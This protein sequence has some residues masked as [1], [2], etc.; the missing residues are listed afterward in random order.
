[1][2]VAAPPAPA[3][4]G[5]PAAPRLLRA[6]PGRVRV[7][8]TGWDGDAADRVAG[9][10]RRIAGV[11]G[12]TVNAVTC[13]AL[14]RY[15]PDATNVER[16]VAAIGALDLGDGPARPSAPSA[17][18]AV[19]EPAPGRARARRARADGAASHP[20][21]KRRVRVAVR[22]LDRDPRVARRAVAALRGRAGVHRVEASATTGR[23]LIEFSEETVDLEDLLS[24]LCAVELPDEPGS[25]HPAHPLDPA[26]LIQST[27]RLIGAGA[28]LT[29]LGVRHVAGRRGA[30]SGGAAVAA[31]FVGVAEGLPPVRR[32]LSALLGH[33][34]AQLALGGASVLTLTLSGSPLGLAVAA[35]GALRLTT[36]V[37]ERRAAWRAY[38]ER[39]EGAASAH[40]GDTVRLDAGQRVPLRARVIE[41]SGTAV[42]RDAL[43][44]PLVPGATVGAGARVLGGPFVVEL[45]EGE[46][47][48]PTGPRAEPP[49]SFV[50][51]YVDAVGVASV[52]FSALTLLLT[53]SPQRALTSLMLLNPRPA[54]IGAEA[55]GTGASARVLRAGVTVVGTRPDRTIER[56]DVLVLDGPRV[57]ADAFELAGI[58]PLA[59]ADRTE[60]AELVAAVSAAAASPWG[61]ALR[62]RS[63]L[64]A[65]EGSFDGERAEAVLG[66]RRYALGAPA[67]G[68]PRAAPLRARGEHA[69]VLSGPGG[70]DLA[71]V[72]LRPR[73][74]PGLAELVARCRDSDVELVLAGGRDPETARALTRRAGVPLLVE[75][76]AL[77][78][79]RE[80]QQAGARV[81][82]VADG[83]HAAEGFAVANLGIALT[84]GRSGRFPARADLLAPD[85]SAVAAIVDAGVRRDRAVA[86]SVLASGVANVVG[87][88]VGLR[89]APPIRRASLTTYGAALAAIGAGWVL[90]RGGTR[91]RS[92]TARLVD[93]HPERW[94]ALTA[95]Q[96]LR[97]L[98]ASAAGLTSEEAQARQRAPRRAAGG[99]GPLVRGLAAQLRSPLV[100]VL[101]SGAVLSVAIG[102]VADVPII[103][104]VIVANAAIGAWQE[105]QSGRAAEALERLSSAP[106][107]V[108]RDGEEQTVTPDRL[109]PGDVLLL[110]A[111]DRVLAD[112]RVLEARGFEV[113]E[114]ALTGESFPVRKE[115]HGGSDGAHVVLEGSDVT[116]GRAR[117]V[118]FAVGTGTRLGATAAALEA[119]DGDDSPLNRRLGRLLGRSMPVIVGGGL[120]VAASG[121][122]RGR[123]PLGQAAIGASASIAAVPEGLPLLA[124][125]AE[126]AVA[127]RLAARRAYVRRL[128]SVEGLGR[129]D[130]ACFD[131]TG[132]LTEGRL[133]VACVAAPD[134]ASRRRL[135]DLPPR[136]RDVLAV[137]AV[138]SPHP[139]A[140]GALAHPTDVAVVQAARTAG[141]A[142]EVERRRDHEEPFDPVRAFHATAAGGRLCVKGAVE[143]LVPRCA[144][145]QRDGAAVALDEAGRAALLATAERLAAE[146]QRVLMVAAGDDAS[147]AAVRD[148]R[149]LVALG[150]V[151]ISDPLRAGA[152]EA[153]RRCHEAGVRPVMLTGDH[154]AT[155]RAIAGAAGLA[156]NG[157]PVLT[158]DD[159]A[160]LEEA[161][162]D[163]RLEGVEVI[164]R[165][166]PLD[167]LRI[168]ESLRRRGHTVAMTGDGVNDAPAL[169]LADVGVAMGRH[170][171][172][173]ARQAADVVLG[174]DDL[175]T[176]VEALVEGRGFWRNMRQALA[177][178][179][180]GNLGELGLMTGAGMLLG[181]PLL[182]T[183]QILT[184]NLVTDVLPA[185]AVAV[186]PP[187]HRDLSAL[188]REGAAALDTPL[189]NDILRRGAA[190]A[191]PS[192]AAALLAAGGGAPAST[193]GFATVVTTQLAQ[194]LDVG[195]AEGRLT[196]SVVAAV[197]AS[198]GV[199]AATVALPPLRSFLGLALPGP[200]GLLLIA[201]ASAASLVLTRA[202]PGGPP[203]GP[204][205]RPALPAPAPAPA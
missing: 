62:T 155:A 97:S 104:S 105:H 38:E 30:P 183:R 21:R 146:G 95:E 149:E 187:E 195:R 46:A 36:E 202:L 15:D 22:G 8:L 34:G 119:G 71:L 42:G 142:T 51:R 180:G 174:D 5:G 109:V 96:A 116:V 7:H 19:A 56:P 140:A 11:T 59:G 173:V 86:A 159:F 166:T 122:V 124:G 144:A 143:V 100:A 103:A 120:I 156:R 37:R 77:D 24:D 33:D 10:L 47:F 102:A 158:G 67:A 160:Q 111:G 1:M 69:L 114:A 177:L 192:L 14:V 12:A 201:G 112:A 25:D 152:A 83:A 194:T 2:G 70:E 198:G 58:V 204:R 130:V 85:L 43:P 196:P 18:R 101:A 147:A 170:G 45:L 23:V 167:K 98:D 31:A 13:N 106:A 127:R 17:P 132:T 145:V 133:S 9:R 186:Q 115:P 84:S 179:L 199:L 151:G 87:L 189:R 175:A 172:D 63:E 178:L 72:A 66:G 55:A 129:V 68:D 125:V 64:D 139:D 29:L 79:V 126:A 28:G 41:G 20:A 50:S 193:V 4:P 164:A 93:P 171:T 16:I 78:V 154:P 184:I 138:A 107:Q 94:G 76:E 40:P 35:A 110:S 92:V 90:L 88:G 153:V 118:V 131:K 191:L 135:R 197:L 161:E 89:T 32:G 117:A 60:V 137:A 26:P 61:G 108:L 52:G 65:A 150:F 75:A 182:T 205:E 169:R 134:G 157:R 165:I 163:E 128:A 162:L 3:P 91:S 113:D 80:R 168:V 200:A 48:A 136:L 53:R 141:L 123:P 73:L 190:T 181:A 176:L 81:A 54:L 188:T 44:R 148:P 203:R 6:L 39:L 185:V 121:I 57:L 27:A 74:A 49:P 82:L 99:S